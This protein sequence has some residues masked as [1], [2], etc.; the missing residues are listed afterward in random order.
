MTRILLNRKGNLLGAQEN[1]GWCPAS[2]DV[3][4]LSLILQGWGDN[5]V[6]LAGCCED[7]RR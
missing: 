4:L 7:S 1:L 5:D 6:F 3:T 2:S